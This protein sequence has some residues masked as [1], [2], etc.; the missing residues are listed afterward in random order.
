MLEDNPQKLKGRYERFGIQVMMHLQERMDMEFYVRDE[1]FVWFHIKGEK[2]IINEL[3]VLPP[4]R[5]SGISDDMIHRIY[6]IGKGRG[7]TKAIAY[8]DESTNSEE[9]VKKLLLRYMEMGADIDLY[10]ECP[11]HLL[12]ISKEL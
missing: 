4:Y 9:L 12:P 10:E 1:G 3:Y 5:K 11:D 7:C 6:E 8:I 2:I